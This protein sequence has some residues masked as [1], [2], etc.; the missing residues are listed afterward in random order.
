MKILPVTL[1]D[2][3]ELLSIYSPYVLD[4]AVTFE[5]KVPSTEEFCERIKNISAKFPY[6]KA[7]DDDNKIKGYAYAGTFKGR[8][9]YDWCVESTVYVKKDERKKGLGR[10][11]YS[12]LEKSLAEMGI[13]NMNACITVPIT[14]DDPYGTK[15]SMLFHEKMGFSLAGRF[16]KCGY[17]FNRWYDMIWMEKFIASH[18][19]EIKPVRF[20]QWKV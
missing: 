2:A 4:T 5:Y 16:H 14:D 3:E 6:I 7:L 9:A 19:G 17:K 8:S 20:G 12:S 11:L 13:L 10:L 15:D 1:S 18:K